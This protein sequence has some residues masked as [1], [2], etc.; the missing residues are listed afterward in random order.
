MSQIRLSRSVV[1]RIN[2]L[3]LPISDILRQAGLPANL[4]QQEHIRL[5]LAQWFALW[6]A[7][8]A[9]LDDPTMGLQISRLIQDEPYDPLWITALSANSFYGALEKVARY[10]RLFSAEEISLS[11]GDELWLVDII[12][13]ID[14]PPPPIL[15]D[16]TFAHLLEL[17]QRGTGHQIYP[18]KVCFQRD[19]SQRSVYEAFFQSPVEFK[20]AKNQIIFTNEQIKL[21]FKSANPDLL[22]LIEPQLEAALAPLTS[23]HSFVDQVAELLQKRIA[24]SSPSIHDIAQ[25]LHISSRTLQ[26]RLAEEGVAF[27]HLLEQVRHKLAKTYLQASELELTEI[28]FL[29]G[30]QEPG[31]F[32]RAFLQWEGQPPGQW[33][34]TYRA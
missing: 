3:D 24:G 30:Y 34:A 27:Q 17:G 21:P 29:L 18:Q 26:R 9:H 10:K 5:T 25:E 33:R 31:S 2:G 8:A 16:A 19:E 6:S 14:Q 4:F 1:T 12:W 32:H 15:L 13:L 11:Q 23:P 22:A 28:A 20:A 7:F